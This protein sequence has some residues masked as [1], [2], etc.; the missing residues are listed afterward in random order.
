MSAPAFVLLLNALQIVIA[1]IVGATFL[2][3]IIEDTMREAMKFMVLD[4]PW[5]LAATAV[6][7]LLACVALRVTGRAMLVLTGPDV[8][9]SSGLAGRLARGLPR[10]YPL[11]L[12]LVT[13][14]PLLRLAF[15]NHFRDGA[16]LGAGANPHVPWLTN[17]QV[18]LA[19][20][21]AFVLLGGLVAV[22]GRGS[23]TTSNENIFKP[24][25][26][27]LRATVGLTPWV[28]LFCLSVAVMWAMVPK[29][30][31]A[32]EC[33]E[34]LG[35]VSRYARDGLAYCAV[36]VIVFALVC[37]AAIISGQVAVKLASGLFPARAEPS[38][39]TLF[40]LVPVLVVLGIGL[41]IS[42]KLVN[43][44]I[45]PYWSELYGSSMIYYQY[46]IAALFGAIAIVITLI[47][48]LR[49]RSSQSTLSIGCRLVDKSFEGLAEL[50]KLSTTW[51][52]SYL[53]VFAAGVLLSLAFFDISNPWLPT[54]LGSIAIVLAWAAA[55]TVF[56]FPLAY[57]SRWTRF[58]LLATVLLAA[59]VFSALN[60]N[61]NHYVRFVPPTQQETPKPASGATEKSRFGEGLHFRTWLSSR[62]DLDAYDH[63]PVFV[64]ATEGG[65]I[66]AAY[67]TASV[68]AALQDMCPTFAQHVYAIS[69]VSGGSVGAAAF[70]ALSADFAT[71]RAYQPCHF[72][73]SAPDE[74][75]KRLRKV[76][77][78]DLL[79]PLLSGML[80]PDAFQRILP[81]PEAAFDR[82]RSLEVALEEAWSANCEGCQRDRMGRPMDD[83]FSN[84]LTSAVV[85][86]LI[87]NTT[88][89][90]TGRSSHLSTADLSLSQFTS[91][92]AW[93][94]GGWNAYHS[95]GIQG[96][97][98]KDKTL[99]LSTAALVSARFPV[100][101]PAARHERSRYVDGGYF[102]NSGAWMVD[103]LIQ[104]ILEEKI[105]YPA[106]KG[107]P[108]LT[109]AIR[110]AQII[111]IVIRSTPLCMTSQISGECAQEA[112]R[113]GGLGEVMSPIRTLLNTRGARAA[114]SKV[115][116]AAT[117]SLTK[118]I[119]G[120]NQTEAIKA[121]DPA[122]QVFGCWPGPG[123]VAGFD[124][125][126]LSVIELG[127]NSVVGVE[128]PLTWLLSSRARQPIDEAV[129]A[130]VRSD[131]RAL[132]AP[133]GTVS[134]SIQLPS[135]KNAE[136][137]AR[138]GRSAT[139]GEVEL[140][141]CTLSTRKGAP[142]YPTWHVCGS[143]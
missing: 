99:A 65:G 132:L 64:I 75:R 20:G 84:P 111:A 137:A 90:A 103:G 37:Y 23:G 119:C 97:L 22:Y 135:S 35:A 142:D 14:A 10:I 140:I 126:P 124:R 104:Q 45:R 76:L 86:H 72:D 50:E 131:I 38:G 83:L 122:A 101:S 141:L 7:L 94:A 118:V 5:Q 70:S 114:Y 56:A 41:L 12:G 44:P 134:A 79:S 93:E 96:F 26:P 120:L 105:A 55:L 108:R 58:P 52:G 81:F 78:S 13:A 121:T 3:Y 127:F 61:D 63:Y 51:A 4:A 71:A 9:A 39:T 128:V 11:A 46:A 92:I 6:F 91:G 143:L 2:D 77:A 36:D 110:K 67:F 25:R 100:L 30:A 138:E 113:V 125:Y 116:L 107:E 57:L 80:F 21:L 89:V 117:T 95:S 109:E 32:H 73:G 102:E 60:L 53:L 82:A 69:G 40:V 27:V 49:F 15:E 88:E 1:A 29:C 31:V 112:G 18:A 8:Y 48:I 115:T 24:L 33:W 87:L 43:N 42:A 47:E 59:V 106:V 139:S 62:P 34:I 19:A 28:L 129:D 85:P 136:T 17:T 16:A 74:F 130:M 98:P 133:E 54:H 68:L 66:R 123:Y